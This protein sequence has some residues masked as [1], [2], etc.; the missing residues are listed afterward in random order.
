MTFLRYISLPLVAAA[1]LLVSCGSPRATKPVPAPVS[2]ATPEPKPIMMDSVSYSLG[3]LMA[4]NL[5][6]QGFDKIDG[7]SLGMAVEDVISGNTPKISVTKAQEILEAYTAEKSASQNADVKEASEKFLEENAGK[8]GVQ[9]TASGLQ[10]LVL[11]EGTGKRPSASDEVVVHYEGTTIDG[12]VFD[13]SY[14]RGETI[15]FPLG[16]VIPGWTEGLQLMKEGA[17][18][19]FFIPQ[20]LAYGARGAGD[21]IP[22]YSTLIFDVELFEVK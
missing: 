10:Y 14:K 7:Q 9:T 4:Q 2:V 22:P 19:R 5:G 3:L 13:S 17:K 18:Y 8:P 20:N 6:K 11:K 1:A 12:Q 16:N 15:S 21:D